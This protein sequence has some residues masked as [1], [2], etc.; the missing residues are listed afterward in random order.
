M[1]FSAPRR[2]DDGKAFL[3]CQREFALVR[4]PQMVRTTG[5]NSCVNVTF[6]SL[7][8]KIG[9][10]AHFDVNTNVWRS[11]DEVILPA[12]KRLG[13]STG[14][15]QV[16]IVAGRFESSQ[17]LCQNLR[18]V[19]HRSGRRFDLRDISYIS[20]SGSEGLILD[21][22][23]GQLFDRKKPGVMSERDLS[24]W[25]AMMEYLITGNPLIRD[26]TPL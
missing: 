13:I 10:L 26:V 6:V 24:R 17:L 7:K 11:F 22:G 23:S 21:I 16:R 5:F 15:T 19:L 9:G 14:K 3:V 20:E 25:E 2:R 1:E 8:E 12:F 18:D 4:A